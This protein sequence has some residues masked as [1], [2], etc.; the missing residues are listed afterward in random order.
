MVTSHAQLKRSE[1][2]PSDFASMQILKG[3]KPCRYR[4]K[5]DVTRVLEK[6]SRYD[7]TVL[8]CR[9][10]ICVYTRIVF[11]STLAVTNC[12]KKELHSSFYLKA[13][14]RLLNQ[15]ESRAK[16]PAV[17]YLIV[18]ANRTQRPEIKRCS[19]SA[20]RHVM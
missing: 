20:S 10:A 19:T 14:S 1:I 5:Q 13:L 4:K 11:S 8:S 15:T 18:A 2:F 3:Q 9:Q 17:S 16:F 7:A 6:Y 12:M